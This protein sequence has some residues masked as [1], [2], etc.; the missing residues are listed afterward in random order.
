MAASA[1]NDSNPPMSLESSMEVS[2]L[3][4]LLPM[5]G[6]TAL[7]QERVST[8]EKKVQGTLTHDEVSRTKP[9]ASLNIAAANRFI[10][11]AIPDLTAEQRQQL[12][13]IGKQHTEKGQQQR[14]QGGH[15]GGSGGGFGSRKRVAGDAMGVLLDG[16]DADKK[17]QEEESG[18]E[19]SGKGWKRQAVQSTADAAEEVLAVAGTDAGPLK[20]VAAAAGRSGGIEGRNQLQ[21]YGQGQQHSGG[22]LGSEGGPGVLQ[23]L[24]GLKDQMEMEDRDV[25]EVLAAALG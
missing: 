24:S 4:P 17:Q 20:T 2:L 16:G 21:S 6:L 13:Q 19:A 15:G 11:H 9:G 23:E 22:A 1:S 25:E 5:C 14:Q 7:L 3:I 10:D 18:E 12:K 8:Y